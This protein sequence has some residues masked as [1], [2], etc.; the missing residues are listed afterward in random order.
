LK[1]WYAI[2]VPPQKEITVGKILKRRRFEVFVP[3]KVSFRKKNRYTKEKTPVHYPLFPRLM[4]V[5][6][7]DGEGWKA[8]ETLG[9]TH[10][11]IGREGAPTPILM[12][13]MARLIDRSSKGEFCAPQHHRKMRSGR[14]FSTGDRVEILEGPFEGNIVDVVSVTPN[15]EHAE[16]LIR[17]FDTERTVVAP[18]GNLAKAG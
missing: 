3:T 9:L 10:S 4:F 2:Q 8:I 1:P 14:E 12:R 5:R 13:D 11:F 18:V 15:G 6:F 16:I 17:L 7:P